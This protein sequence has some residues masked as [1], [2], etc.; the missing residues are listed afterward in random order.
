MH[1]IRQYLLFTF[2]FEIQFV[3]VS[4]LPADDSAEIDELI[5]LS[6]KNDDA[7]S[8]FSLRFS[9]V[10]GRVS[11]VTPSG[12]EFEKV[13]GKATGTW[14]R[15]GSNELFEI[16]V[17]DVFDME[18]IPDNA[19][20][21][22]ARVPFPGGE[23]I[24]RS[25]RLE[26]KL[27][28]LTGAA[29]IG[30]V[31]VFYPTASFE[32]QNAM[33]VIGEGRYANPLARLLEPEVEYRNELKVEDGKMTVYSTYRDE[34]VATTFDPTANYMIT[35]VV[36]INK[37]YK[38]EFVVVENKRLPNGS[39]IPWKAY[40]LFAHQVDTSPSVAHLWS[41]SEIE[42]SE[43]LINLDSK[44]EHGFQL[45]NDWSNKLGWISKDA[46]L[47][48]TALDEIY[49][50]PESGS[51]YPFSEQR[52]E[53]DQ[54]SKEPDATGLDAWLY[55]VGLCGI[56]AFVLGLLWAIRRR[57]IVAS[58]V[59]AV[60]V[61]S[62]VL[63]Q[64]AISDDGETVAIYRLE[65]NLVGA[66]RFR[67]IE[68][69]SN[70]YF[71]SHCGYRLLESE[72]VQEEIGFTSATRRKLEEVLRMH[73]EQI[74]AGLGLTKADSVRTLGQQM[75]FPIPPSLVEKANQVRA[76]LSKPQIRRLNEID[77]YL[78]LRRQGTTYF[79]ELL[80][81][82]EDVDE[83]G[84]TRI[85]TRES[86]LRVEAYK[87][88]RQKWLDTLNKIPILLRSDPE[89]LGWWD[90]RKV[91]FQA[92]IYADLICQ[93]V[94]LPSFSDY[95]GE[96]I[97]EK[98][99]PT[100]FE[101][102]VCLRLD[103]DGRW[104]LT[105]YPVD[106]SLRPFFELCAVAQNEQANFQSNVLDLSIEQIDELSAV[107]Q[108][109]SK[110]AYAIPNLRQSQYK[111]VAVRHATKAWNEV[112][113]P[114]QR[115]LIVELM[116]ERYRTMTGPLEVLFRS[117]LDEDTKN[118]IREE[119]DGCRKELLTIEAQLYSDLLAVLKKELQCPS[120]I[121]GQVRPKY[122]QPSLFLMEVHLIEQGH[123]PKPQLEIIQDHLD[124]QR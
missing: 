42:T 96:P 116:R 84:R 103:Q 15:I 20:V 56:I 41:A 11:S 48:P 35:K 117:D 25:S 50:S 104:S 5:A 2:I 121:T 54:T 70:Y 64:P 23:Q 91:R 51:A 123:L 69:D 34:V 72:H 24:L 109:V 40:G 6:I 43:D 61:S 26:L 4:G 82:L 63:S 13:T 33:M 17:G 110:E 94:D 105:I 8:P 7:A 67:V 118:E 112:L 87:K 98:S 122:L 78:T 108:S 81:L 113:L 124:R 62:F 12:I 19:G 30:R 29:K 21:Q 32:P 99:F 66:P 14:A 36:S 95:L 88:A 55:L 106:T 92:G 97:H 37:G 27:S 44:A 71:F 31:G 89:T 120:M 38:A 28:S 114:R 22:F 74:I 49:V 79:S 75:S 53:A 10:S 1:A 80:G 18:I 46:V 47:D 76:L 119:F 3:I 65:Q 90:H 85:A 100:I 107:R 73:H 101:E 9:A 58:G 86:E 39:C 93:H 77:Q 45:T 57:S 60:L 83:S 111:E 16:R 68:F 102:D 52:P 59:S 115:D